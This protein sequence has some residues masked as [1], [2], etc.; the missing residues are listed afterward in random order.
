VS[1]SG[2][3]TV[4]S[5]PLQPC[6]RLAQNSCYATTYSKRLGYTFLVAML[7]AMLVSNIKIRSHNVRIVVTLRFTSV[8]PASF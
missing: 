6:F 1:V 3:P 7:P 8:N 4:V 5:G 2:P